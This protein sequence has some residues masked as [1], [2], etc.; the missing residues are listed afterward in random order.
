MQYLGSVLHGDGQSTHEVNRRIAIARADFDSLCKVWTRAPL[1][2][3]RKLHIY[4]ALVE[5][6]LLYA[7]ASLALTVAQ[8]RR[9]NGFQNRCLRKVIGV[10]PAYISRISNATVIE[11]ANYRTATCL[12]LKRRLQLFGKVLRAPSGHPLR[13]AC[14]IP[15]TLIPA[16]DRYVRRVGRPCKEWIK[17][18]IAEASIRFGSMQ[19]VVALAACKTTWNA[20]LSIELGY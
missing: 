11:R 8:Q 9:L 17:E 14:F 2:W 3:K 4:V 20:A 7:M 5:S 12:L 19:Q 18:T 1:S 10:A 15:H 16:T 6:K 13:D